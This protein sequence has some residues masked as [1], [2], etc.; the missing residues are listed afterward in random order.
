MNDRRDRLNVPPDS[1]PELYLRDAGNE[2]H[3]V[4]I[5]VNNVGLQQLIHLPMACACNKWQI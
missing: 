1:G 3:A 4:G 5:M 2:H